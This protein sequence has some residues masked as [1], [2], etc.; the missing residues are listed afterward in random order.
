MGEPVHIKV[1]REP[2]V[3]RPVDAYGQR[4]KELSG[5]RTV[6]RPIGQIGKDIIPRKKRTDTTYTPTRLVNAINKYFVHC[7]NN[8]D[9][10]TI[11][12]M[13]IHLKLYRSTFYRYVE[14]PKFQ[15]IMEHARL[16]IKN[17]AEVDVYN[18]PGQAAGK[19]AFMKNV[20]GWSD[21]LETKNETEIKQVMSAEQATAKIS[22]LAPLLL[23]LLGDRR[24]VEQLGA[25]VED[26]E[27][28]NE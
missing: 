12:G 1:D 15:D 25:T 8:D 7:E 24:L 18:S 22:E 23:G 16:M 27:I 9:V 6:K 26:A 4:K 19:I 28:V 11:S 10:P 13:M 21:K 5:N 14:N 17:W 3:A 20:H 2:A